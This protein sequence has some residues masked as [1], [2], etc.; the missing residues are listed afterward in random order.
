MRQLL[1]LTTSHPDKTYPFKIRGVIT[2][3]DDRLGGFFLQSGPDGVQVDAQMRAGLS[4]NVGQEGS[5]VELRGS[6]F[7][8][9]IRPEEFATFLGKGTMPEPARPSWDEL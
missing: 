8:D 3:I 4:A 2:Y 9:W 5:F 1:E 7:G 6:A